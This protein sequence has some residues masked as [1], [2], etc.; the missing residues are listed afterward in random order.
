MKTLITLGGTREPVDAVRY[1]GNRSSGRM[2]VA[3]AAAAVEAGNEVTVVAGSVSVALPGDVE[4]VRVDTTR[5][6]HDAVL[7]RWPTC[8][9]LVMAAAVADFRP[10]VVSDRKLHRDAGMTLELE[11]TED[12]LAAAG[13]CKRADQTLVGFSLDDDTPEARERAREKLVR[14]NC[15]LL[16]YNPI[17][18]LDANE[19][20]ATIFRRDGSSVDVPS[21][22]KAAFAQRLIEEVIHHR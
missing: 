1:L 5:Q 7:E 17:A 11:P 20:T 19:V 4:V 15:D 3:I 6:M 14:K 18:T 22:E 21:S 10:K 9:A 12:I 2:G 8:D 16:V 13:A